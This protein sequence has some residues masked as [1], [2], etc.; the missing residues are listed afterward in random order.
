MNLFKMCAALRG[1]SRPTGG[2]SNYQCAE[3][4]TLGT[5]RPGLKLWLW[6]FLFCLEKAKDTEVSLFPIQSAELW[7]GIYFPFLPGV[8]GGHGTEF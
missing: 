7:M 1:D 5:D 2:P 4:W 6:Y 3:A 8:Q